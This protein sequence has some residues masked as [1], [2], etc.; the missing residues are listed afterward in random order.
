MDSTISP[1]RTWTIAGLLSVAGFI[2]YF[3]RAIISIALP[4]IGVELH[5]GPAAKG[6]LLSAFFWSYAL[7]QLPMG[8]AADR[9][10]LRWF[11]AGAFALWSLACGFTGFAAGLGALL[12]M[13]AALG[14]GES[15]Y[16]PGGMKIVSV[17]FSPKDRGLASGIMD[18][19]TRA[20]LAIGAPLIALLIRS[21]GWHHAFF[22]L[23]FGS[24]IWLIPWLAIFPSRVHARP[25]QPPPSLTQNLRKFDRNILGMCLGHVSYGYYWYLLVT[26]LPDYLVESRHMPLQRAAAFA[27]IPYLVFSASEPLGGWIADRMMRFGYS[28]RR[29]RKIVVTVSFFTSLMLLVAG[30]LENDLAAVLALGAASLV[31]LSTGNIYAL[32]ASVAP[33]NSVGM[34]IGFLQF[35]GNVPG[36]LAPIIT[37]LLIERTGSYYPGFVVAVVVLILG[38]P[39]YWLLVSDDKAVT[40]RRPVP[41]PTGGS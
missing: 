6:V 25:A 28:E 41:E 12:A 18:C 40:P 3:D 17:L 37:G 5:L 35:S 11:Y 22:V 14:I 30:R 29:S 13:R 15:V 9:V 4:I 16:M 8:W 10:N 2:N 19:G 36:V 20:G 34:W 23:G 38:L 24:L 33:E 7:M 1:A 21:V 32:V 26:W 39:S 27:V 31:G